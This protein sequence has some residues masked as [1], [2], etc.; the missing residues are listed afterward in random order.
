M[1][2][3]SGDSKVQIDKLATDL[4]H[5]IVDRVHD[6]PGVLHGDRFFDVDHSGEGDLQTAQIF[7]NAEINGKSI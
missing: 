7:P 3:N 6:L 1:P 5:A 2:A 4:V